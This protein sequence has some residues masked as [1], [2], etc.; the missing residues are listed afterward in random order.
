MARRFFPALRIDGRPWFGAASAAAPSRA[1]A[2]AHTNR[3]VALANGRSETDDE[4]QHAQ[5]SGELSDVENNAPPHESMAEGADPA[6]QAVAGLTC[7]VFY[8]SCFR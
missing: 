6:A 1:F 2:H 4:Q 3:D 7:A 8:Q 5:P